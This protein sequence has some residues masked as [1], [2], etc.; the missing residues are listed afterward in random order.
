M[1]R[2]RERPIGGAPPLREPPPPEPVPI[3]T[4]D[5]EPLAPPREDDEDAVEEDDDGDWR[6]DTGTPRSGT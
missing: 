6:K 5:G 2:R 4:D 1:S 3:P